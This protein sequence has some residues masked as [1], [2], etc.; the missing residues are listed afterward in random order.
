MRKILAGFTLATALGLCGSAAF[1]GD[2]LHDVQPIGDAPVRLMPA[3][4]EAGA[5]AGPGQPA[6]GPMQ[7]IRQAIGNDGQ[8]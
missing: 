1:A 7:Q 8:Q 3:Q 4:Y 5:M 6:L 2:D